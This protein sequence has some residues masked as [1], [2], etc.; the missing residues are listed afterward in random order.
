[1]LF[2]CRVDPFS[3][4]LPYLLYG[5]LGLALL[6]F[7]WLR[8][9]NILR[10][11]G[12]GSGPVVTAEAILLHKGEGTG[13]R[14]RMQPHSRRV[15]RPGDTTTFQLESGRQVQLTLPYQK[16]GLLTPGDRGRLTFQG[17]RYLGFVRQ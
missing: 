3:Q 6:G 15:W 5:L 7:A 2:G 8:L 17:T 13:A 9:G 1:M 16:Y 4:A 12:G 10:A 14:G 11:L